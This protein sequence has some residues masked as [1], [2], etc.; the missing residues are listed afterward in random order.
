MSE[1]PHPLENPSFNEAPL[2]YLVETALDELSEEEKRK[3]L[4]QIR[5]VRQVPQK[6]KKATSGKQAKVMD[7]I[8]HLL[9]D[10]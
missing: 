5:E 4:Q 3:M 8:A 1:K 6:R 10:D 7:T 2:H 9:G